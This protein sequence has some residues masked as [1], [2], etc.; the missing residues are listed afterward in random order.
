MDVH[1]Q[2]RATTDS[3]KNVRK[4]QPRTASSNDV[5]KHRELEE[6]LVAADDLQVGDLPELLTLFADRTLAWSDSTRRLRSAA[7]LFTYVARASRSRCEE[8]V[9]LGGILLLGEV[10][11][12]AAESLDNSVGLL[13]RSDFDEETGMRA[14][15][16]LKCLRSL[17]LAEA[18]AE[19]EIMSSLAR[20]QVLH[21]TIGSEKVMLGGIVDLSKLARDIRQ[22]WQ[23]K[24]VE[25]S[26]TLAPTDSPSTVALVG[27]EPL[28]IKAT[29]LIAQGLPGTVQGRLLAEKVEVALFALHGGATPMYRQQARMLKSNLSLAGN[30]DLRARLLSG[31]MAVEQLVGMDSA[32]LAP[33]ALQEQRRAEQAKAFS[34][35]LIS[36]PEPV[37]KSDGEPRTPAKTDGERTP[38]RSP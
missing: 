12:E 7:L 22:K 20:L 8:F 19:G 11:A 32:A 10:L 14:L 15:A 24:K 30:A 21:P 16:C 6:R 25:A 4:K 29:D 18:P 13:R 37:P 31:G 1:S 35:T 9:S 34:Q 36:A 26:P 33:E 3:S 38:R 5:G 27:A 23:D 17:S 2:K 28:R